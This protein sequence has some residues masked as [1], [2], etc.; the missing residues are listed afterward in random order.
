MLTSCQQKSNVFTSYDLTNFTQ[1]DMYQCALA[2]RNM[3]VGAKSMEEVANRAVRYLYERLVDQQNGNRACT[4]VRFFKTHSYGELNEELQQSAS[5][6]LAGHAPELYTK[7]LTLLATAG[8]E[9]SWNS[10][11]ASTGHQAIPLVDGKFVNQ[12]PMISE[13][14]QQFNVDLETI[15]KPHPELLMR[16]HGRNF[17]LFYVPEALGS[18]YI[19][20]QEKFVIPYQIRSVLGFGGRLCSGNIFLIIMFSKVLIPIHTIELFK[21]LSAYTR[22]A[23][24]TFDSGPVFKGEKKALHNKDMN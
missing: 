23:V 6:V 19:P 3:D 22:L 4:L 5:K 15:I 16:T 21:F 1:N 12:I 8:D 24:A 13:L 9:P 17:K 10:R 7:C 11:Q 2:L 20:A 18:V 14:I